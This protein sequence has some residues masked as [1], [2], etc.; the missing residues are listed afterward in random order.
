MSKPSLEEEYHRLKMTLKAYQAFF[1]SLAFSELP[2]MAY[3]F[4]GG[5]GFAE[6]VE[7]LARATIAALPSL[8]EATRG[9]AEMPSGDTLDKLAYHYT[10]HSAAREITKDMTI[11]LFKPVRVDRNKLVFEA[12]KC[13]HSIEDNPLVPAAYVGVIVGV[14]RALGA[15][16]YGVSDPKARRHLAG[17]GGVYMVYPDVKERCRI[18]VE[19]LE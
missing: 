16:A 15:K 7:A 12:D 19:Y 17:R 10:C 11:G 13:P 6:V 9:I 5:A 14:L 18:V 4:L 1:R 8:I 3:Q 2:R